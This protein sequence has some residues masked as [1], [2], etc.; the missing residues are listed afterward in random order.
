[1]SM[2][3]G[4]NGQYSYASDFGLLYFNARWVDPVLG[5]F[6]Q[7]DTIVPAGVQGYDRYAYVN[8]NP[9]RYT[10]PSGHAPSCDDWDDCDGEVSGCSV[11]TGSFNGSFTCTPDDLND[12]TIEQRR[13]WFNSMLESQDPDLVQE[14]TNING[15][16]VI[17]TATNTGAPGTWASWTDAGILASIQNGLAMSKDKNY[18]QGLY[19]HA[20]LADKAWFDFFE[21]FKSTG[22]SNETLKKWG[23][24]EGAGTSYGKLLAQWHLQT[25]STRETLFL[26][27]GNVYRSALSVR[28]DP[29]TMTP[30][31]GAVYGFVMD[32]SSTIPIF[33]QN[34]P[35]VSIVAYLLLHK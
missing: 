16:L 13:D 31:V 14:F 3:Y 7:A 4:F 26:E 5:R 8:N 22:A 23:A 17:F 29:A 9:V 24:A 18:I 30:T 12:A 11:S 2:G 34:V 15:I 25:P 1:M 33:G 19:F 35:P 32:T 28:Q 20:D 6:A 10:D 21:S 27:V